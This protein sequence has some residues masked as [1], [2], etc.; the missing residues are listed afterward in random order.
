MNHASTDPRFRDHPGL[1]LYGIESY[2]A[3]PLNRRD[4]SFFGTLC[5][6][7]P[8]PADLSSDDFEIFSLLAQ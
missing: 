7:D 4:G 8:L 5:A 2:I 1:H 6:L 3:V